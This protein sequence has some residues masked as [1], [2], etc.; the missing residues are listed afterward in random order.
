MKK[1]VFTFLY[2]I[3]CLN[4]SAKNLQS[5]LGIKDQIITY[6][7]TPSTM[8]FDSS[9]LLEIYA[10]DGYSKEMIKL[11]GTYTYNFKIKNKITYLEIKNSK[12]KK[13]FLV[14]LNEDLIYLFE[15]GNKNIFWEGKRNFHSQGYYLFSEP[16]WLKNKQLSVSSELKEKDTVYGVQNLGTLECGKPW[17]E[18]VKGNGKGE[19][20][21]NVISGGTIYI[22]SGFV[23]V[24]RPELYLKNSRPKTL[25]I[26]TDDKIFYAQLKDTPNPQAITIYED[27]ERG[28][29]YSIKIT[30]IDVYSGTKYEDTCINAIMGNSL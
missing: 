11:H 24:D 7:E 8:T 4:L 5:I 19:Y 25:L 10:E 18:G 29:E 28:K 16:D 12:V 22:F 6:Y 20:I 1:I 14:L 23:D 3:V 9:G 13:E 2:L 26:E 15:K 30:I 27:I 17:V 21:K